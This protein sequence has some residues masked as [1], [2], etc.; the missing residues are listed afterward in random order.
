MTDP[1][2][3]TE[4]LD[5]NR[6]DAFRF[7]GSGSLAGGVWGCR[8]CD[9][10]TLSSCRTGGAAAAV[11]VERGERRGDAI[12]CITDPC[13]GR[14]IRRGAVRCRGEGQPT[15]CRDHT[16]TART[17]RPNN[18]SFLLRLVHFSG[19][20]GNLFAQQSRIR[21]RVKVNEREEVGEKL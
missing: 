12:P 8:K 20:G 17:C 6:L 11:G 2:L 18:S 9:V 19:L 7:R 14:G 15:W 5:L 21:V 3:L 1:G 4:C 16:M 10:R 13:G